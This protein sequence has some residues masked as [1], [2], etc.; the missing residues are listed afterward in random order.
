MSSFVALDD[1]HGL[2]VRYYAQQRDHFPYRLA[3]AFAAEDSVYV[4]ATVR[5]QGV[6][7]SIAAALLEHA[8][9]QEFKQILVAIGGSNNFG[10]VGVHASLGLPRRD[11]AQGGVQIRPVERYDGD[12]GELGYHEMAFRQ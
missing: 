11:H 2:D 9:A 6:G 4:R 10:S 7:K 1:F 12:A 5:G 3:Y 8:A